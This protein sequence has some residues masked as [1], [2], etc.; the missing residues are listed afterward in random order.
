MKGFS[1]YQGGCNLSTT[2]LDNPKSAPTFAIISFLLW[3]KSWK[4]LTPK[5][6]WFFVANTKKICQ[7]CPIHPSP[8]PKAKNCK[9][10]FHK[11][12]GANG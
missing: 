10:P 2:P 1:P 6:I 5:P 9:T 3:K 8:M 7:K 4:S 11:R 12:R